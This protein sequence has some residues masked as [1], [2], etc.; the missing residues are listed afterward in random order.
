MMSSSIENE[1]SFSPLKVKKHWD[2]IEAMVSSIVYTGKVSGS[3]PVKPK[4][5]AISVVWPFPVSDKE[6]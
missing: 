5:I 2:R 4:I 3:N 1:M 6:T